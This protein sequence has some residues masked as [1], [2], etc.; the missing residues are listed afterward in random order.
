MNKHL[1]P[2]W[3]DLEQAAYAYGMLC[4]NLQDAKYSNLPRDFIRKLERVAEEQ[5]SE[6]QQA[7][8]THWGNVY[9][10]GD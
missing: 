8:L 5:L 2:A 10:G 1:N 6:L 7:A 4:A 9:D 3:T